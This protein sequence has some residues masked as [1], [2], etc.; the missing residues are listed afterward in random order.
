MRNI[1]FKGC[2]TIVLININHLQSDLDV[3]LIVG[4]VIGGIAFVAIVGLVVFLVMARRKRKG[5]GH[6]KPVTPVYVTKYGGTK[7]SITCT[8]YLVNRMVAHIIW[9]AHDV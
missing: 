5:E 4:P 3:G 1:R 8:G 2:T 6:Y 7:V 9:T